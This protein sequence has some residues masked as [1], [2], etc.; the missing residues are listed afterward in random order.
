MFPSKRLVHK[1]LAGHSFF[2]KLSAYD[3]KARNAVSAEE[4][5]DMYLK[6][7]N[8]FTDKEKH[9]L[10]YLS[11]EADKRTHPF[12]KLHKIPWMFVK[13]GHG[14][15]NDF[16]HTMLDYIM[17]PFDFLYNHKTETLIETLIHEKIHIFQRRYALETNILITKYWS[18]DIYSLNDSVISKRANPDTNDILYTRNNLECIQRYNSR[19]PSSLRDSFREKECTYEHPYEEM[20]Y[21]LAEMIMRDIYTTDDHIQ[22][23]KWI[24]IYMK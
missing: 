8:E 12:K 20:A 2:N 6:S 5:R 21:I 24:K 9:K 18:Y 23:L 15:E 16:P 10:L 13:T 14:I 1:S 4:Y 22:A 3:V 7:I 11:N 17:L 19:E